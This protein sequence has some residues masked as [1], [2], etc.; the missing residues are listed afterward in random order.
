THD[1]EG[2]LAVSGRIV[3]MD[4]GHIAEAG[5]PAELFAAPRT[6]FV[7]DFLAEA[8][9]AAARLIAV[10]GELA[11][12]EIAG[13]TIRVPHRGHAPGPVT[14]AIRPDALRVTDDGR[15]GGIPGRIL[16]AAF[17]GRVVEYTID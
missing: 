17:V 2:A 6:A 5:A 15:G 13:H 16:R 4:G 7:A 3:V 12:V 14:V 9:L 11:D 1:R 8:N 10:T